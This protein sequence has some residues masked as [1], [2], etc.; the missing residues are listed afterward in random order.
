MWSLGHSVREIERSHQRVVIEETATTG[1]VWF[2]GGSALLTLLL[3]V[4]RPRSSRSTLA[5]EAVGAFAVLFFASL[6]LYASVRSTYTADRP[7]GQL[8]IER[9]IL[10]ST[11]RTAYDAHTI[12]RVYVRHTQKGSGLYVRFKSGRKKRLS[13]SLEF[14]SLEALTVA[15]NTTLYTHHEP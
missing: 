8:T 14:I 2:F 6:A 10:F 3:W 13:M 1:G 7:S 5:E 11:I 12:D 4:T 9:R 15:L